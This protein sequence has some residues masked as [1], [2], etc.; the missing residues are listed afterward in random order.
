MDGMTGICVVCLARLQYSDGICDSCVERGALAAAIAKQ[1][2]AAPD[3]WYSPPDPTDDE[4]EPDVTSVDALCVEA[5]RRGDS[6]PWRALEWLLFTYRRSPSRYEVELLEC[7]SRRLRS[8]MTPAALEAF[9]LGATRD[10]WA[11]CHKIAAARS[12]RPSGWETTLANMI[13]R[14]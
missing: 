1:R 9:D 13:R 3:S 7:V 2:E 12:T 4:R 5:L 14:A 10:E 6:D 8:A 11:A